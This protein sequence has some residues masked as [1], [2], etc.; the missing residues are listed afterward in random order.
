MDFYS[1][2][3]TIHDNIKKLKQSTISIF[4]A[5]ESLIRIFL[6]SP[7]GTFTAIPFKE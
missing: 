2:N 7:V 5:L 6:E 4:L 1:T 3:I